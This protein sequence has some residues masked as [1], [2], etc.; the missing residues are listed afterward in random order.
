MPWSRLLPTVNEALMV[1]IG[2]GGYAGPRI[3]PD[4][5][6]LFVFR[7]TGQI[8]IRDRVYTARAGDVYCYSANA[9]HTI[10][11]DGEHPFLLGGVHFD[12]D[13][14]DLEPL[15]ARP[16]YTGLEK[17]QDETVGI[18][19]ASAR[20]PEY[21]NLSLHHPAYRLMAVLVETFE[22]RSEDH[23]WA[24]RGI[25]IQ[26]LASLLKSVPTVQPEFKY[27][28]YDHKIR[29]QL[30]AL[31]AEGKLQHMK[32]E[33]LAE[34]LNLSTSY[35]F[36]IFK[37]CFG[38]SPQSYLITS[39]VMAAKKLLRESLDS[40]EQIADRCGFGNVHYFYRV[41]KKA[42]GVTPA[43]YRQQSRNSL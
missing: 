15:G 16:I 7:G 36:H 24:C 5:Q 37:A 26:L 13:R 20:I 11:G 1:Q 38:V 25:M 17:A 23:A 4:H 10:V 3:N 12:L 28:E 27:Y 9:M 2:A 32:V 30:N 40:L 41:F 34:K 43:A 22:N 19:L 18:E 21:L 6:I 33:M 29:S 42:E 31:E 39:R 14:A 8:V 35:F